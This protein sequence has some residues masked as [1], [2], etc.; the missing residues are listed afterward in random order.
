MVPDSI[1]SESQEAAKVVMSAMLELPSESE[2]ELVLDSKMEVALDSED[3]T[4]DDI[5]LDSEKVAVEDVIE[6]P[7]SVDP[8]LSVE[9]LDSV[10]SVGLRGDG[11]GFLAARSF[12][13]RSLRSRP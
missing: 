12:C 2:M 6:A 7:D 3:V 1:T 8:L 4:V 5:G 9:G 10:V 13:L 11:V